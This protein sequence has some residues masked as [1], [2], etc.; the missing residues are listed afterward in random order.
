MW[1]MRY[2]T[3]LGFFSSIF[4]WWSCQ[5]P[6]LGWQDLITILILTNYRTLAIFTSSLD[7]CTVCMFVDLKTT[8]IGTTTT[9][10]TASFRSHAKWLHSWTGGCLL[11]MSTIFGE[12]FPFSRI[13]QRVIYVGDCDIT[14]LPLYLVQSENDLHLLRKWEVFPEWHACPESNLLCLQCSWAAVRHRT[15]K[16]VEITVVVPTRVIS[17]FHTSHRYL[18]YI[19]TYIGPKYVKIVIPEIHLQEGIL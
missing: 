12:H 7:Q 13:M 6:V 14:A 4:T 10:F 11:S 19:H 16:L 1:W 18:T 5:F 3:F 2:F 8:V 15:Q 17:N 9:V